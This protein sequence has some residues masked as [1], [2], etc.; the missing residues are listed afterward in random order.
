MSVAIVFGA[1]LLAAGESMT[2]LPLPG[3]ESGIGFDDL[4]FSPSLGRLL[5]TKLPVYN[6][7]TVSFDYL[8]ILSD[9]D[10]FDQALINENLAIQVA[11]VVVFPKQGL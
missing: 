8:S 1:L 5:F 6:G 7:S 11:D 3:G 2:P 9:N 4:R 10:A